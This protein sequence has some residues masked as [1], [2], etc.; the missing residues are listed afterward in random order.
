MSPSFYTIDD[1]NFVAG[2][3]PPTN[4]RQIVWQ[5][6]PGVY[7][8]AAEGGFYKTTDYGVTWGIM[9]PNAEFGTLW[10]G[11]AI[12][13]QT[14]MAF[15]PRTCPD[16]EAACE[17]RPYTISS[18]NNAGGASTP[19]DGFVLDDNI[20][21]DGIAICDAFNPIGD[22][23]YLAYLAD[24]G[25]D[26]LLSYN[27]DDVE[28]W[29]L[30]IVASRQEE[31]N[32]D[33]PVVSSEVVRN[34]ELVNS[35]AFGDGSRLS[36]F[37][38][39][40]TDPPVA[41]SIFADFSQDQEAVSSLARIFTAT[42]IDVEPIVSS[43]T[44]VGVDVGATF[45]IEMNLPS[46]HG[47]FDHTWIV[48]DDGGGEAAGA[49]GIALLLNLNCVAATMFWRG[50]HL[51]TIP[52]IAT[53]LVFNIDN[54]LQ[55]DNK[56][57]IVVYSYTEL[58]DDPGIISISSPDLQDIQEITFTSYPGGF[59]EAG[60]F[61]WKVNLFTAK[62]AVGNPATIVVTVE[63]DSSDEVA[64][65]ADAFEITGSGLL[66]IIQD[67][68]D[69][70]LL[71]MI[72]PNPVT[73]SNKTYVIVGSNATGSFVPPDEDWNLAEN[74]PGPQFGYCYG[75]EKAQLTTWDSSI[76]PGIDI[77]GIIFELG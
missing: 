26:C 20:N 19:F 31:G 7:I 24:G 37:K 67:N 59:T 39:I 15:G 25:A 63:T 36:V 22:K 27:G 14:S 18:F 76:V 65:G 47:D 51:T 66:S 10:P 46:S 9:R 60:N 49:A 16:A 32:P 8:A 28:K 53:E 3:N 2:G 74:V 35:V 13:Y 54:P 40:F 11:S 17:V 43:F 75:Y 56:F 33:I 62:A 38:G 34:I 4:V 52:T 45:E 1:E 55:S 57:F 71:N 68:E 41:Q 23:D 61:R 69:S 72:L 44:K 73:G 42:P 29:I 6:F 70:D 5:G 50:G 77:I 30:F 58:A 21:A 64:I 48:D 12:G